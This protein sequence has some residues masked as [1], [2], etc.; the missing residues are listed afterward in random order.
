MSWIRTLGLVLWLG[1][2]GIAQAQEGAEE[3]RATTFQAVE[4]PQKESVPGGPL[5]IG[6]YG[7]VLA[8]LLAYVARLGLMQR[9]TAAEVERLS[10]L[11]EQKRK[12]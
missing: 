10:A 3:S 5:L 8:A 1:W 4:G 11:L 7:F 12:A 6:A 9:R 2:S